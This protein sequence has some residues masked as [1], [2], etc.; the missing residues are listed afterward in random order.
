MRDRVDLRL[1]PV[2]TEAKIALNTR[3]MRRSL[4][5]DFHLAGECRKTQC[6]NDHT[7]ASVGIVNALR[8]RA[9][10]ITCRRPDTCRRLRCHLKHA[11]QKEDGT[12]D[13]EIVEWV[14]PSKAILASEDEWSSWD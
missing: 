6:R 8:H 7:A 4:C 12:V 2:S 3:Q 11:H 1:T 9:R 5:L 10:E 13:S 14:K